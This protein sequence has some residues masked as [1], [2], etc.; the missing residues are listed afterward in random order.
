MLNEK[1]NL[2]KEKN[3][4]VHCITNYVT[5]NDCAN[6][7][8]ASGASPIMAD[9][10]KEVCDITSIC[11]SLVINIGT[12]NESTIEAMYLSTKEAIKL[13]HKVVFDPVGVGAS[14]LRNET[15]LTFIQ[16][17]TFNVIKGNISEIKFLANV[18]NSSRGVD[19]CEEDKITEDNIHSVIKFAKEFAK[20]T[21]S[22]IVITG[23]KD[24]VC[25]ED[26]AYVIKNGHS[27]M[28]NV[29]GTGCMLS[30]LIG[31]FIA[32]NDND[33]ESCVAAVVMMGLSGEYAYE[34]LLELDGGSSTYKCLLIDFISKIDQAMLEKGA[35]IEVF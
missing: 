14:K 35:K 33:L 27:M 17:F 7:L 20:K 6:V 4:L 21:K 29:S 13:K 28:S 34:K 3:P 2:L 1:L 23:E 30:A 25:N 5:V 22:I 10:K 11:S 18:A 31:A 15:A 24:I 26:I 8:I 12:L 19:A 9:D 16:Q 32:A